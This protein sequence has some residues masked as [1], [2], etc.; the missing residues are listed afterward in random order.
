MPR[1]HVVVHGDVTVGDALAAARAEGA[2][3]I[4][5]LHERE[6]LGAAV[7]FDTAAGAAS[8]DA[9]TTVLDLDPPAT[10]PD[11]TARALLERIRD[12]GLDWV[13]VTTAAGRFLGAVDG[14][15]LAELAR[16]D[17]LP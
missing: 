7:T 4:V 15:A 6:V 5:V 10:R 17:R 14:D 13:A 1:R 12:E 3:L 16:S 9:L 11:A 8:S 2:S